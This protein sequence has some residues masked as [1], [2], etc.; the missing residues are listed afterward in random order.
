MKLGF[1]LLPVRCASYTVLSTL[2]VERRTATEAC[3]KQLVLLILKEPP[4]KG[5]L[6]EHNPAEPA[7]PVPSEKWR[8]KQFEVLD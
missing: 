5:S 1:W 3:E 4:A 8:L 6:P 7:N 2:S